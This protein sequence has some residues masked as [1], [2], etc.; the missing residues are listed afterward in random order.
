MTFIKNIENSTWLYQLITVLQ[1]IHISIIYT[2][3]FLCTGQYNYYLKYKNPYK[4]RP[5]EEQRCGRA[6][7]FSNTF[8]IFKYHI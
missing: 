8:S 4:Y 6:E 2:F 3:L 1:D 7:P 5:I